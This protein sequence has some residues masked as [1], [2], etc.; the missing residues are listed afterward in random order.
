MDFVD[1]LIHL[2]DNF[3]REFSAEVYQPVLEAMFKSNL[4]RPHRGAIFINCSNTTQTTSTLK[5]NITLLPYYNYNYNLN[6]LD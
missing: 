3:L 1:C 5:K 2:N 6:R 4:V